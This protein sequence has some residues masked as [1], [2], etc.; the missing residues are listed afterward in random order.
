MLESVTMRTVR[1]TRH[2]AKYNRSRP[3]KKYSQKTVSVKPH[4]KKVNIK[5]LTTAE[6]KAIM[7]SRT[8]R[9]IKQDRRRRGK[10]PVNDTTWGKHPNRYDMEG[11]DTPGAKTQPEPEVIS[12]GMKDNFRI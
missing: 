12:K 5:K 9:A 11:F 3:G 10:I 6:K 4:D 1:E 8:S 7:A 2:I